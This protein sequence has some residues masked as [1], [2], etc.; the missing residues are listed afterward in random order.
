MAFFFQFENDIKDL[1]NLFIHNPHKMSRSSVSLTM[2]RL[3][4][5]IY[6]LSQGIFREIIVRQT[7][8]G[9]YIDITIQY[10]G[11][12]VDEAHMI[13]PTIFRSDLNKAFREVQCACARKLLT[14][15][16]S[17]LKNDRP[18]VEQED[19]MLRS[20]EMSDA[21]LEESDS[22]DSSDIME[23]VME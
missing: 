18:Y 21:M 11:Y 6:H 5:D 20:L 23:T 12:T 4:T 13:I 22:S 2:V 19:I 17:V 8:P 3:S 16:W 14:V 7:T 10:L 15:V 9:D 1:R